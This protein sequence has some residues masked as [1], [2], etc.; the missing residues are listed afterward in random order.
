[1]A[2]MV[3]ALKILVFLQLLLSTTFVA[4]GNPKRG[5]TVVQGSESDLVKASSGQCSWFYNWSPTPPASTHAGLEFVAMQWGRE[6]IAQFANIVRRNGAKTVLGFN[7]PDLPGQSNIPPAEA[8]QLWQQYIQPLKSTGVRLGSPAVSSAPNGVPWLSSFIKACTGCTIDF[9]V[10][11]W[12]GEGADNFIRYLANVHAQFPQHPIWIT[13][14]ADSST[15]AGDV[16]IFMD[17]VL[18][19]LDEQPWIE[20]YSWFAFARTLGGLQ[21][22]LLDGNGNFNALGSSYI[23]GSSLRARRAHARRRR[24]SIGT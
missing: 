4:G 16:T 9:V 23:A 11:H 19:Y 12:Y 21:S 15:N 24:L 5:L 22:N 10:V 14:F 20:R 1:M 18:R 3:P 8:A 17:T 2:S 13:E 6:D 7:E